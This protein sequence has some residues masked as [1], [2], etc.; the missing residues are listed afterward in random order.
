M[1]RITITLF[2]LALMLGA[3]LI[4]AGSAGANT[5]F[6][7]ADRNVC[8]FQNSNYTGNVESFSATNPANR[9]TWIFIPQ[10]LRGS[11]NNNTDSDVEVWTASNNNSLC[12]LPRTRVPLDN[13]F[14]YFYLHYGVANTCAGIPGGP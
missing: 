10:G 2:T 1:K 11:V 6:T 4:T 7:D 8:F 5:L 3:I 12:V 13:L 9:D 14:G